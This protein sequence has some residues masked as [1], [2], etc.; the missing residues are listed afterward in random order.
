MAHEIDYMTIADEFT[1]REQALKDLKQWVGG[2]AKFKKLSQIAL[3]EKAKGYNR[4]SMEAS[5]SLFHGVSG[6][7]V[8]VWLDFLGFAP[9]TPITPPK[10]AE[11]QAKSGEVG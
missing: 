2:A 8:Q 6:L 5:M 1:R 7:P 3:E 10:A 4:E 9:R 11:T